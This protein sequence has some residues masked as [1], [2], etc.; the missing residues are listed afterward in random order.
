MISRSVFGCRSCVDLESDLDNIT[1]TSSSFKKT[2]TK[3]TKQRIVLKILRGVPVLKFLQSFA[4]DFHIFVCS[5]SR[6][7]LADK[8]IQNLKKWF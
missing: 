3:A 7:F 1:N 6:D 4:L 2:M 8:C 5:F